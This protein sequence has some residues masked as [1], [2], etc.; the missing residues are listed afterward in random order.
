MGSESITATI[1][2]STKASVRSPRLEGWMRGRIRYILL[3][4]NLL[5]LELLAVQLVHSS[6][7]VGSRLVLDK[8]VTATIIWS[9]KISVRSPRLEE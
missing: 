4:G 7:Q 3:A 2:W 5:V 8:F 1:I 6:L 9:T